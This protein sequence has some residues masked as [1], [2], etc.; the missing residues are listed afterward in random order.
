MRYVL[1]V[2]DAAT[3]EQDGIHHTDFESVD[4]ISTYDRHDD[5]VRAGELALLG[6]HDT[7]VIPTAYRGIA[8]FNA[9]VAS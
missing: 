8:T 9:G 7:Y 2:G 6:G 1:I 3:Y 5:A 4:F